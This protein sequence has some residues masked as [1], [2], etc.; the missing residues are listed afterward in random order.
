MAKITYTMMATKCCQDRTHA[1][2]DESLTHLEDDAAEHDMPALIETSAIR[3]KSFYEEAHRFRIFV[4][5]DGLRRDCSAVS[6]N[7][8]SYKILICETSDNS[9]ALIKRLT[10]DRKM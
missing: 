5:R 9:R 4:I 6:L 8:K 7:S 2:M 3:K 10:Q 1:C